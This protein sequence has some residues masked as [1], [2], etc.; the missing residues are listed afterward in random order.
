VHPNRAG[1]PWPLP[2]TPLL[3]V[4]PFGN[5]SGDPEQDYSAHGMVEEI[6]AAP[7]RR[8]RRSSGF[9]YKGRNI[10]FR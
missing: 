1:N 5:P 6:T 9:T 7:S 3:A 10:D 2:A 8:D 4:L